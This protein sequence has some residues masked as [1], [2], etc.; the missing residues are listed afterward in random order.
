MLHVG[1]VVKFQMHSVHVARKEEHR[2]RGVQFAKDS[3][4]M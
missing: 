1:V 4:D 3:T 2:G